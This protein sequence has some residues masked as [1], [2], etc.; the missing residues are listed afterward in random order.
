MSRHHHFYTGLAI[1]RYYSDLTRGRGHIG[2]QNMV[3]CAKR[4]EYVVYK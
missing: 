3:A 2:S 1:I 4:M